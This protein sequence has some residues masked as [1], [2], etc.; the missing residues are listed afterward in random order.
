MPN[1]DTDRRQDMKGSLHTHAAKEM[2]TSLHSMMDVCGAFG[3]RTSK[4]FE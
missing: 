3:C 4:E 1:R 2:A